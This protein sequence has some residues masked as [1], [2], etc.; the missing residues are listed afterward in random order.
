MQCPYCITEISP[1]ALACPNCTRD[2][3]LFKPLLNRIESLEAALAEQGRVQLEALEVRL[4]GLEERLSGLA[5]VTVAPL[6]QADADAPLASAASEPVARRSPLRAVALLVA[7]VG[8][9]L[10]AH[11]L[12]LFVYDARPI[13][14]RVVSMVVPLVFGILWHRMR[15]AS[16]GFDAGIGFMTAAVAVMGMLYV[17]ARIDKVPVFP[18]GA[19]EI[20]E[21]FEY[22]MSIGLAFITG[23]LL[24]RLMKSPGRAVPGKLARAVASTLTSDKESA[25]ERLAARIQRVAAVVSPVAAAAASVYTGVKALTGDG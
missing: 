2:L 17:T 9:L 12:L 4:A 22:V 13:Y 24:V 5:T 23:V 14:L 3:Y 8:L 19:R 18:D 1:A 11:L 21:V 16:L 25:I 6:A 20:R 15:P 10:G 7:L